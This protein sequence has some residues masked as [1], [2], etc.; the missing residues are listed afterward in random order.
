MM[1]DT[2]MN[3]LLILSDQHSVGA[4]GCYG[5]DQIAT[6]HLD[7]LAAEG[8]VFD[9]AYCQGPLCVPSRTSL[10]TGQYC[11]NHGVYDNQHILEANSSTLPRWLGEH[12]YRTCLIGK[13]HFNGEQYHGYQQRPYGDLW[14]QAHQPDPAW[15]LSKGESGL[16]DLIGQSGPSRIPLAL[17]QTEIC[18]AEAAKW[19][20]Y[21]VDRAPNQPFFLSVQFDKPH[22]PWNPPARYFDPYVDRVALPAFD[23]EELVRAVPFVQAAASR[24]PHRFDGNGHSEADHARTLAAYYGCVSWVDDAVGRL[25]E[26]IR[27]LGLA[28]RTLIIYTTDHGDMLGAHG[29]W[30]KTV[31]FESSSRVPLMMAGPGIPQELRVADPVGHIDLFPTVCQWTD[32]PVPDGLDGVDLTPGLVGLPIGRDAIFS[33]SVVLK[34]PE[35]AGCMIRTGPWKYNYYLDGSEELYQLLDDPGETHSLAGSM[36]HAAIQRELRGRVQAFWEPAQQRS[37]YDR[38][39]RM[40]REKHFYRWSNQFVGSGGEIFNGRP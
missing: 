16:G 19:L 11:R 6:P 12:G 33:E 14:G 40:R 21:H 2:P 37:R 39:P 35:Y 28:G 13:A 5:N 38:T 7:Q 9:N 34:Q 22:F 27:Y 17:T 24:A 25:L 8:A 3:V 10:I 36:G 26:M 20:L 29:L 4:L 18:V 1:A 31:F 15:T 30:Q 32:T 23:D